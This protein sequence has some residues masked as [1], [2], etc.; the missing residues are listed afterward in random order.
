MRL[1]APLFATLA[2][3]FAAACSIGDGGDDLFDAG[4]AA[5]FAPGSVTT[6]VQTDGEG[7]APSREL[8]GVHFV[9]HLVR[10]EDGEFRALYP[11]DPHRGCAVAWR[12]DFEW[13]GRTGWFR[14]SCHGELYDISGTRVSGP[15]P[16]D[17]DRFPVAVVDGRVIVTTSLDALILGAASAQPAAATDERPPQPTEAA[18]AGSEGGPEMEITSSAFAHE[19]PIPERFSCDGDDISPPLAIAG[20]PEGTQ[21]LVLIMDDPDAPVG[22]WDHWVE[23]NIPASTANIPE[24]VGMLGTAGNNSWGRTGYG[25]PCPPGGTHRYLFKLYALDIAL[26]LDEGSAKQTVEAAMAGHVLA[27]AE[28]IGLYTR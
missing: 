12:P 8:L 25:G 6:F 24:A 27:N 5:S 2:L 28:L 3:L 19:D 11:Y 17:L 20:I 21:T 15:S 7:L 23:F 18:T 16:R 13:E 22:T 4:A 10:L 14:N 1:P 26:D 9:V